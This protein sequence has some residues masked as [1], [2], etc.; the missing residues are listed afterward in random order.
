M[1]I[2]PIHLVYTCLYKCVYC[3]HVYFVQ[4][5]VC[6][7]PPYMHVLLFVVS[8]RT[9]VNSCSVASTLC[10]MHGLWFLRYRE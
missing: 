4:T 9:T 2:H 7:L 10:S 6:V 3:T 1:G 5:L 8:T